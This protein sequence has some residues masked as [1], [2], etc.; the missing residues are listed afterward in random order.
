MS[1]VQAHCPAPVC[2]TIGSALKSSFCISVCLS[3]MH[4]L[5]NEVRLEDGNGGVLPGVEL[6]SESDSLSS[7]GLKLCPAHTLPTSITCS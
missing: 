6:V 4:T 2:K 3:C 1:V 7:G 5:V